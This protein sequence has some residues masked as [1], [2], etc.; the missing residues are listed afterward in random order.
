MTGVQTCALPICSIEHG[1][2]VEGK[3]VQPKEAGA[4][5]G[6]RYEAGTTVV[7]QPID[8]GKTLVRAT[9]MNLCKGI[10][11]H[12]TQAAGTYT[13]RDDTSCASV[14]VMVHRAAATKLRLLAYLMPITR[15]VDSVFVRPPRVELLAGKVTGFKLRR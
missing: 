1:A 11:V 4:R 7:K 13:R 3:N 9:R 15:P 6:G 2:C 8:A 5:P 10:T 12:G 14:R